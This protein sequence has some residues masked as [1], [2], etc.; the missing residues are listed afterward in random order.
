MPQPKMTD[1]EK[2]IVKLLKEAKTNPDALEDV[3]SLNRQFREENAPAV[4]GKT[5]PDQ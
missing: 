5:A 4:D 3:F 1:L 2:M